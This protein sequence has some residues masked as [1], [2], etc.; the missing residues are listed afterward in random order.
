MNRF[1]FFLAMMSIFEAVIAQ[2]D[3]PKDNSK[4]TNL[5]NQLDNLLQFKTT[6]N[7]NTYGYNPK[8][9]WAPSEIFSLITEVPFLYNDK[10]KKFGLSDMRIRAFFVPYK[11][12]EKTVGSFGAS[13]DVGLPT[14]SFENGLG[15]SSWRISPGFIIGFIL[16]KAQTIS[17]FP[18][19]SYTYTSEPSSPLVPEYLKETDHGFTFQVISSFVLSKNAFFLLTPIY[20]V[21]DF[22]DE[23]EDEFIIELEPVFDIMKDK[24]QVG[25]LYRGELSSSIHSFSLNFTLFL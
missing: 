1:I 23:K 3:V 5:Y 7:F 8:L 16:N 4:P 19:L 6:P 17:I 20:D 18:N 15:S 14:G 25:F 9:S 11:N 2:D 22:G 13:L 10:T 24:Y 21:K 12:Y